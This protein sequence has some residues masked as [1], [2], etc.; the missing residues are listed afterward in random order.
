MGNAAAAPAR[1]ASNWNPANAITASRF[2]T[3]PLFYWAVDGGD[4]Q[5]ATL[6]LL[7]C[8]LLDMVDGVVARIFRC[9]TPFGEVFDAIAD[10]ICYGFFMVV[11][12]AFGLLPLAPVVITVALG[13]YNTVLRT[14]YAKRAGRTVN[15][16]SW[17]MEKLVAYG[18]YNVLF[19]ITQI[20]VGFYLWGF[21]ALMV[22]TLAHDTRRLLFDPIDP[23]EV[24]A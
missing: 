19:G 11:L 2:G 6:A 16:R 5:I 21:V 12:T 8:A 14:A 9:Q 17:A 24:A 23:P 3:L 4:P 22:V 20:E 7:I 13:V 15:Y 10:A 18:G 1:R